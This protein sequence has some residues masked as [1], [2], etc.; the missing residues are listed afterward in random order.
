MFEVEVQ[1]VGNE[2]FKYTQA[3]R[4]WEKRTRASLSASACT[5]VRRSITVE[6]RNPGRRIAP[7]LC[8]YE[9]RAVGQLI[10]VVAFHRKVDTKTRIKELLSQKKNW[11]EAGGGDAQLFVVDVVRSARHRPVETRLD[12]CCAGTQKRCS[13]D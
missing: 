6:R 8:E 5:R 1:S 7:R 4:R 13:G 10:L 11:N 3:E 2:T 9:I 12:T